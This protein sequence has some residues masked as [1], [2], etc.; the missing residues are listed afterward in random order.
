MTSQCHAQP[1]AI[2]NN[3]TH[4]HVGHFDGAITCSN[5]HTG[6][7]KLIIYWLVIVNWPGPE[8]MTTYKMADTLTAN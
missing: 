6:D 2:Y 1:V 3:I 8:K 4:F 5:G 7:G